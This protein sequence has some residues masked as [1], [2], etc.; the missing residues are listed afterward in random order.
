MLDLAV[1]VLSYQTKDITLRCLRELGR[2]RER[3]P[4]QVI[5]VD[6]A[7]KDGSPEAIAAEMPWVRLIRNA[8]NRGFA[9]AV[10]QAVSVSRSRAILLLNSDC[11]L[12]DPATLEGALASLFADPRIAVLGVDVRHEDGRKYD[13]TRPFPTVRRYI[14]TA[15]AGEREYPPPPDDGVPRPVDVD[16]MNGAFFLI[17]REA[18]EAI[19]P[20]DERF[21]FGWEDLDFCLRAHRAGWR[22]VQDPRLR[23]THLGGASAKKRSGDVVVGRNNML[24]WTTLAGREKFWRKNYGWLATQVLRVAMVAMSSARWLAH[25]ARGRAADATVEAIRVKHALGARNPRA[26]GG[27]QSGDAPSPEAL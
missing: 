19:G 26:P 24:L 11:F 9:A 7:S 25:R 3:V 1:V 20:L 21:F 15:L 8:R 4:M 14:A 23:V 2:A 10:N 16:W 18:W 6:N 17:R 12:G 22:V 27:P 5:V 13:C